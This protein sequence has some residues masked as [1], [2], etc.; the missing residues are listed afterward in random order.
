MKLNECV[1][2][3]ET[4]INITTNSTAL[5]LDQLQLLNEAW[6]TIKDTLKP[7]IVPKE[8]RGDTTNEL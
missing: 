2:I 6:D 3:I 5:T 7:I 1:D 4:E 8:R